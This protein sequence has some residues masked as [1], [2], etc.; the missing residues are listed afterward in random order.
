LFERVEVDQVVQ[1]PVVLLLLHVVLACSP[2]LVFLVI[3]VVAI[4][5]AVIVAVAV[6]AV[7]VIVKVVRCSVHLLLEVLPDV[8]PLLEHP[9]RRDVVG[10]V[11]IVEV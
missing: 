6:I 3:S 4:A 10:K 9:Q 7:V 5:V 11:F 2:P 8:Q 1:G